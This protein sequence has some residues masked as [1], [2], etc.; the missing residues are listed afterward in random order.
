MKQGEEMVS[1]KELLLTPQAA[2]AFIQRFCM[3]AGQKQKTEKKP[4]LSQTWINN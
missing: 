2:T 4:P 1:M 3:V